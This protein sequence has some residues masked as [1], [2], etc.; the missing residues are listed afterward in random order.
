[1]GTGRLGI[2]LLV[3]GVDVF[4]SRN[5][6]E[7]AGGGGGMPAE[8]DTWICFKKSPPGPSVLFLPQWGIPHSTCLGLG[9]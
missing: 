3:P 1:M 7:A 8:R 2:C 4:P 6:D 9:L 5:H